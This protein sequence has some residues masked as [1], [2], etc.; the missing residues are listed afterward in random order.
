MQVMNFI[1]ACSLKNQ[2]FD[3]S[4]DELLRKALE[5]KLFEDK[6]DTIKWAS[7]TSEVVDKEEQKK[8]DIIKERMIK[9]HGYCDVCSTDVLNYVSSIYARGDP[10]E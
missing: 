6:K 5:L 9:N 4:S 7:I 1:A 3:Y 8:I 10:K 2:E